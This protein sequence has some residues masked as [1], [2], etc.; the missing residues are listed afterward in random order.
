MKRL[1]CDNRHEGRWSVVL[2]EHFPRGVFRG[3][4]RY[5]EVR[6][7]AGHILVVGRALSICYIETQ[8]KRWPRKACAAERRVSEMICTFDSIVALVVSIQSQ[9]QVLS[10]PGD[11]GPRRWWDSTRRRH[12]WITFA[13]YSSIFYTFHTAPRFAVSTYT[14]ITTCVSSITLRLFDNIPPGLVWRRAWRERC[15]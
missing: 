9:R 13:F 10:C 11:S 5:L 6:H 7:W 8:L 14:W 15:Q 1:V 12:L 4:R 3:T 2:A